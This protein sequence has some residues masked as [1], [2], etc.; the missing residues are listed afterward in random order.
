MQSNNEFII[1][2]QME[3]TVS[4]KPQKT[5][6]KNL[7]ILS[8]VNS[9]KWSEISLLWYWSYPPICRTLKIIFIFVSLEFY[10][11]WQDATK[12]IAKTTVPKT[13]IATA[14]SARVFI[15]LKLM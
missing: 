2:P 5:T 7:K 10:L 9:S 6:K 15:Y 1:A 8:E 4:L 12:A 11:V 3:S 14:A 13:T